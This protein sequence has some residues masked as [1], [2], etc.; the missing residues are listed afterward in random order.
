MLSYPDWTK[1][2]PLK[3]QVPSHMCHSEFTRN[4]GLAFVLLVASISLSKGV[5]IKS[6]MLFT[7]VSDSRSLWHE[8]DFVLVVF[9]TNY[10]VQSRFHPPTI[11]LS[12]TQFHLH[13]RS[14]CTR[15]SYLV[16]M[17]WDL[18][19]RIT[20]TGTNKTSDATV[21][22]HFYTQHGYSKV[23]W[24]AVV[25]SFWHCNLCGNPL[26]VGGCSYLKGW[27]EMKMLWKHCWTLSSDYLF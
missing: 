12:T 4:L 19:L 5:A 27:F 11:W 15:S 16:L 14:L 20:L 25:S 26:T 3:I 13:V 10:P 18:W 23:G 21:V 22:L 1:T 17:V 2:L 8:Q 24:S 7:L 6:S 9:V